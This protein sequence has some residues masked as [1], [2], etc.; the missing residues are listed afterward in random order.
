MNLEGQLM[1]SFLSSAILQL[2]E[3][4]IGFMIVAAC[5]LTFVVL[6][7]LSQKKKEKE[8]LTPHINI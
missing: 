5:S 1:D 6:M 4:E 7:C 2:A 3:R 8:F